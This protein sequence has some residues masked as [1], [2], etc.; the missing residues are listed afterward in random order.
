[1]RNESLNNTCILFDKEDEAQQKAI[2]KFYGD[3]GWEST[4]WLSNDSI[5]SE[6][7]CI[8]IH[9]GELGKW[10]SDGGTM[11]VIELPSE[12]YPKIVE[13]E[14]KA[15]E[16]KVLIKKRIVE[17]NEADAI[18]CKERWDMSL[19]E[20][21]RL[22]AREESNKVTFARQELEKILKLGK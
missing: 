17:L 14:S 1:M 7:D 11:Q 22:M 4:R 10:F 2:I 9:R 8:G 15:V 12:Y 6:I 16:F 21:Q 3:N 13:S 5:S 19:P 20:I 18:F